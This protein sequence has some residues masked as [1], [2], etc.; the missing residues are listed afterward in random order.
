MV[1]IDFEK[2]TQEHAS[3][4]PTILMGTTP[5]NRDRDI[6]IPGVGIDSAWKI[7]QEH[8]DLRPSDLQKVKDLCEEMKGD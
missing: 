7:I 8:Y 2:L 1:D 6:V 5:P 3:S 4:E